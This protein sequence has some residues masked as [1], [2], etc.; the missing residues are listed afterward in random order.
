MRRR[1]RAVTR[2]RPSGVTATP[3]A[4]GTA[5][6]RS[7]RRPRVS[8]IAT[9]PRSS[10]TAAT[11][12]PRPRP[13][14]PPRPRRRTEPSSA[15][16]SVR[17][18]RSRSP[19]TAYSRLPSGETA[20]PLVGALPCDARAISVRSL[21]SRET[22]VAPAATNPRAPSLST[23][24]AVLG[25][26][27]ASRA[28]TRS[29]ET[30]SSASSGVPVATSAT[31]ADAADS[32]ASANASAVRTTTSR[33]LNSSQRSRT[34]EI[35]RRFERAIVVAD[36]DPGDR[37]HPPGASA[38]TRQ[39]ECRQARRGLRSRPDA[40][41]CSPCRRARWRAASGCRP[42]RRSC[43]SAGRRRSC[44]RGRRWRRS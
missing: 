17:R 31:R 11:R 6:R 30:S 34:P 39:G 36:G 40:R 23:A 7:S 41:R 12:P 37:P 25:A 10:T 27:S 43:R 35:K 26:G 21:T 22:I 44:R 5:T 28:T 16:V 13:S 3:V 9:R 24:T 18:I 32:G 33:G 42:W 2:T 19:C 29:D 4:P 38:R 15:S 20:S 1:P 8:T 14:A